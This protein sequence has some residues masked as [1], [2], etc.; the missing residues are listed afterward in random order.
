MVKGGKLLWRKF[1]RKLGPKKSRIV[2]L[3]KAKM[4]DLVVCVPNAFFFSL[5]VCSVVIL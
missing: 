4:S 3:D 2:D 1:E 5:K